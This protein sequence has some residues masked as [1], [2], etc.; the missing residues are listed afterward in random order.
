MMMT[1]SKTPAQM[2][3]VDLDGAPTIMLG[4]RPWH[5]PRLAHAQNKVIVPLLAGIM[6]RLMHALIAM[7]SADESAIIR[8]LDVLDAPTYEALGTAVHAALKRGYP[9]V[10]IGEF[11]QFPIEPI[12]LLKALPVIMTQSG[13]FKQQPKEDTATGEAG[14]T[15]SP[16]SP[17][18]QV[19]TGTAS[20]SAS[21]APPAGPGT[22]SST[23]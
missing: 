15:Q 9:Q 19:S 23:P 4:E 14:A 12:E 3:P 18:G 7:Q 10:S 2:F 8:A 16:A 1:E 20:L 11:E 21:S 22:T 13:F 17:T 6:P 5:I